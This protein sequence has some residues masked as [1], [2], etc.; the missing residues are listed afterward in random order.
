MS[1][2][3]GAYWSGWSIVVVVIV[4][5]VSNRVSRRKIRLSQSHR[6]SGNHLV[7]SSISRDSE[8]EAAVKLIECCT[9][10]YCIA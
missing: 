4:V 6:V 3:H 1:D 2:V 8:D 9:V 5:D 7:I 10:I